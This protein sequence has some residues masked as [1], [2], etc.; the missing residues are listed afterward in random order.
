MIMKYLTKSS[1]PVNFHNS[2]YF[3]YTAI[4][5]L[6]NI[7]FFM[8]FVISYFNNLHLNFLINFEIYLS[9]L[10][11]LYIYNFFFEKYKEKYV[12]KK[13]LDNNESEIKLLKAEE[14]YRKEFLGNVSHELKTPIFNI[15]GYI[16]T[17]LDGAIKDDNVNIKYLKR[18]KKN[19]NRLISIVE[20]LLTIS[21][22]ETHELKLNIVNFDINELI[23]DVFDLFEIKKTENN[24]NLRFETIKKRLLVSADREYITEVFTNLISNSLL[25]GKKEGTTKVK[26][27]ENQEKITVTVTDDGIGIKKKYLNRIFERFFR[28][29]KSRSK[30][31]GGTGLG[32]SIVKH[33]INGHN[34]EIYVKS[35]I[36]K[37]TS[38]K[39]SLK[40][41]NN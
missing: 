37:G 26:I 25:Y 15:Q 40:K 7:I 18:T 13:S 34:E 19:I 27:T 21:K 14:K 30:E 29:D 9:I 4:F 23:Y 20:D 32:L 36:G 35:E 24:I 3:K 17:L 11:T 33:I 6:T 28:I 41:A 22:L 39:F 31:L 16:Y 8:I 1:P 2:I 38:F 12:N 5:I 10:F